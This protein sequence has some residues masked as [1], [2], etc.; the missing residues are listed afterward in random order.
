MRRVFLG[1]MGSLGMAAAAMAVMTPTQPAIKSTGP[2]VW[3]RAPK[4]P[5]TPDPKMGKKMRA[6]NAKKGVGTARI[7]PTMLAIEERRRAKI[8][9]RAA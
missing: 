3:R 8:A 6:L 2:Q 9:A 1:M 7:C 4:P 5:R